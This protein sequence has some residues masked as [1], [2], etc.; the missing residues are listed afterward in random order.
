[1]KKYQEAT[2]R[3]LLLVI[4]NAQFILKLEDFEEKG[5]LVKF[6]HSLTT[7]N[8][9]DVVLVFNNQGYADEYICKAGD[10]GITHAKFNSPSND[11]FAKYLTEEIADYMEENNLKYKGE[12]HNKFAKVFIEVF[13][14][15]LKVL[16]KMLKALKAGKVSSVEGFVDIIAEKKVKKQE[17]L[18][19][20]IAERKEK[21]LIEFE[22]SNYLERLRITFN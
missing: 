16:R 17:H 2:G 11:R 13:G 18:Q 12:Y 20:K 22:I 15:N 14:G 10:I 3:R 4:D 6:L 7:G 8:A 1:M 21:L 19:K 9:A 5:R